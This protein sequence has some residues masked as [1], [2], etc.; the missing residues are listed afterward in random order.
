MMQKWRTPIQVDGKV[1]RDADGY[2]VKTIGQLMIGGW[3][4]SPGNLHRPGAADLA[5]I[6][7]TRRTG[8][9]LRAS[10]RSLRGRR[11]SNDPGGTPTQR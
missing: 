7:A 8:D 5:D 10:R 1:R 3:L 4:V 9:D 2:L 11:P 6:R